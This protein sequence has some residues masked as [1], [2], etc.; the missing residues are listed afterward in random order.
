MTPE[1]IEDVLFLQ[2][3]LNNCIKENYGSLSTPEI[4]SVVICF[5]THIVYS[6]GLPKEKAD[7]VLVHSIITGKS[8]AENTNKE[9]EHET[10][11]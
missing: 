5:G 11:N 1:H 10:R 2:H 4:A 7:Y 3:A 6:C 8:M 9:K